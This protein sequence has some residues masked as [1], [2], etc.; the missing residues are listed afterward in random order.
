MNVDAV[1]SILM[2]VNK[3]HNLGGVRYTGLP[4]NPEN[5]V[6][7][8]FST[9]KVTSCYHH[10]ISSLPPQYQLQFPPALPLDLHLALHLDLPKG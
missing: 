10:Q 9:W 5:T 8:R 4:L 2:T 3:K 1:V 6:V 7:Q